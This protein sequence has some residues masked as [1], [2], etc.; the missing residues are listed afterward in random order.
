[1][2]K[3]PREN[4]GSTDGLRRRGWG[5]IEAVLAITAG[6]VLSIPLL[7]L[8]ISTRSDTCKAINYLRALEIA[9]ETT[10]WIQSTPLTQKTIETLTKM[11]GSLVDP[12][13]GNSALYPTS[14]NPKWAGDLSS[15]VDY[16]DQYKGMYF[17]RH[18]DIVPVTGTGVPHGEYLY[19]VTVTVLWNENQ[20]PAHLTDPVR[21]KKVVLS[22]LVGDERRGY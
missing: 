15:K 19:Q 7:W 17:F 9:Q 13:T 5:I 11:S 21:A 18:I 12:G 2:V 4:G 3:K 1:M 22:T 6:A 20:P 8:Y 14:T 10:E 16:P